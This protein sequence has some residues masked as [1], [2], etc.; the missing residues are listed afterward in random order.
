MK[1]NT[2]TALTLI[3]F[4]T[5]FM[6]MTVQGAGLQLMPGSPNFG[7][8]GAGHAAAGFGAGS[9]WANPATMVL[10]EDQ[11]IGF[12]IIA[13]ETDI[14]FNPDDPDGTG[15]DAGGNIYI[16]SFAYVNKI[17]ENVSVGFSL[18]VPYGNSLSYDED[19]DGNNVVNDVSLQTVQ[20]M[21]SFAY[22]INEQFSIGLGISANHTSV[23]QTLNMNVPVP[24]M[25]VH[26]TELEADSLDYGYTVGGLYEI[27]ENHRLG[28]VYRSQIDSDLKGTADISGGGKL[29]PLNGNYDAALDW[30]NPASIVF[31]GVHQVSEKTSLLWDVGR[32]FYSAFE[33]TDVSLEDAII[34]GLPTI[35]RD[36][37]DANRYAIGTHYQLTDKV[38]LQAGYAYEDS[39]VSDEN[40][41]VDLP[42]DTIQRF[43]AGVLYQMNTSTELGFA[44]EY[45]SLG[46]AVII[47]DPS[48]AP[49][50]SPSGSYDNSAIAASFSVNHRF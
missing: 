31:S 42:L 23:E 10:V 27:N 12:G 11:Q 1:N 46:N 41:T 3:A 15:S 19:W 14:T 47:N 25:G 20:A 35:H 17:N 13:A 48:T 4:S 28:F 6:S 44:M 39:V 37:E 38:I 16:P 40:R 21:P 33:T 34:S 7:T 26:D 32:T 24:G 8:A 30:V 45:A 5:P 18:T 43:S 9:A 22:R 2:R 29:S 49:L 50:D 36:W